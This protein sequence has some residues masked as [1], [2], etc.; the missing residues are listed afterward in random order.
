MKSFPGFVAEWM[1]GIEIRETNR[2]SCVD[3]SSSRVIK[4]Q[5]IWAL[6]VKGSVSIDAFSAVARAV[7]GEKLTLVNFNTSVGN[8]V[9][10]IAFS[11]SKWNI[12]AIYALVT[13]SFAMGGAAELSSIPTG[14]IVYTSI[15]LVF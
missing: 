2:L 8:A 6:A 12:A 13:P 10:H 5:P 3:A 11:A 14:N 4:G 1:G 9:E 15:V 7:L